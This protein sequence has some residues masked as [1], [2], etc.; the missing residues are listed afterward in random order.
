MSIEVSFGGNHDE[1]RRGGML[2]RGQK[3]VTV[4]R[5]L[6]HVARDVLAALASAGGRVDL[7][8]L[9]GTLGGLEA[10]SVRRAVQRLERQ[11]VLGAGFRRGR[12]AQQWGG[13]ARVKVVW[14]VAPKEDT[15]D[16]ETVYAPDVYRHQA[17]FE[18]H[19]YLSH[20]E[21]LTRGWSQWM[22]YLFLKGKADLT[23]RL[24]TSAERY[25]GT[26]YLRQ[27]VLSI[28]AQPEFQRRWQRLQKSRERRRARPS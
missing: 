3:G 1:T 16:E 8:T 10:R 7:P 23:L 2:P 22:I 27:R 24:G 15:Q 28:E 17:G 6:G 26:L 20:S 5:G 12:H 11:G 4:S 9:V 21:L 14:L 25:T 13:A 18:A 19:P